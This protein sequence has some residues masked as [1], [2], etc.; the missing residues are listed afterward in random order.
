MWI[1]SMMEQ[2]FWESILKTI[3]FIQSARNADKQAK[4]WSK[5]WFHFFADTHHTQ[6]IYKSCNLMRFIRDPILLIRN[7]LACQHCLSNN[8]FH[9]QQ[10]AKNRRI[11]N[12]SKFIWNPCKHQGN[13]LLDSK[14]LARFIHHQDMMTESGN[15]NESE[16]NNSQL[17]SP[18]EW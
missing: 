11:T 15:K 7:L 14:S 3:W 9:H 10:K 1:L 12:P 6:N 18:K 5:V 17:T 13:T 2:F 8:L 16:V 4:C